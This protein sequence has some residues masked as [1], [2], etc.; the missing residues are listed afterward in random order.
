MHEME[1]TYSPLIGVLTGSITMK[2]S[3]EIQI[4]K[5]KTRNKTTT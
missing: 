1:N 2:T 5:Q 3:V 4:T